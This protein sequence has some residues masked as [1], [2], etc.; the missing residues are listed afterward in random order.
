MQAYGNPPPPLFQAV[1]WENRADGR[2]WAEDGVPCMVPVSICRTGT[3]F[4]GE[5]GLLFGTRQGSVPAPP[6]HPVLPR[7]YAQTAGDSGVSA[8]EL[9]GILNEARKTP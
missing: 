5:P 2:V 3:E 7:I 1:L 4:G 6:V 8:I 9:F